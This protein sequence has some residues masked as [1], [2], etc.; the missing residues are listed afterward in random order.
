MF[1]VISGDSEQGACAEIER[2]CLSLSIRGV[3]ESMSGRETLLG[4]HFWLRTLRHGRFARR[5]RH[6]TGGLRGLLS[7]A[8]SSK[9]H[10]ALGEEPASASE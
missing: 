3:S 8:V 2:R 5:E 4:S 9:I 7:T 6:R 10:E 1:G